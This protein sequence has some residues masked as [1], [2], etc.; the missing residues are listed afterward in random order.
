MGVFY[1]LPHHPKRAVP[2][3]KLNVVRLPV[4]VCVCVCVMYNVYIYIYIY[5]IQ[6][7]IYIPT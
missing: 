1:L 7:K 5:I 3:R 2:L 6:Y 4:C